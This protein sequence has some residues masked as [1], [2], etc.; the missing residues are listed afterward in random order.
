MQIVLSACL[1]YLKL[2]SNTVVSLTSLIKSQQT[3]YNSDSLLWQDIITVLKVGTICT[4]IE[5][6]NVSMAI[7]KHKCWIIWQMSMV[8]DEYSDGGV[9][10]WFS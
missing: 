1:I 4:W 10:I 3:Y 9:I 8:T 5:M 6:W 7:Y 2:L